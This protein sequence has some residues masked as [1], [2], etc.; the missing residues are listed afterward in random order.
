MPKSQQS[1]STTPNPQ[2]A[3]AMEQP[4]E[5]SSNRLPSYVFAR[6]TTAGP[7]DWS[8][9]SSESLFSIQMGNMSYTREQLNWMSKSGEH[10]YSHNLTP[11]ETPDNNQITAEITGQRSDSKE[12]SNG[13][14]EASE[15]E[16]MEKESQHKDNVPQD[17][18]HSTSVSR[19]SD[20]SLKSFAFPIL[21]GEADKNG[22]EAPCTKN[23]NQ[24]SLPSTPETIP[25]IPSETAS[26]QQTPP[27]S[28]KVEGESPKEASESPKETPKSPAPNAPKSGGP[29]KWLGCFSCCSS[30]S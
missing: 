18:P 28:P 1:D 20:A 7:T 24:P 14:I 13:V 26:K 25:E 6:T 5:E 16:T 9:C 22:T 27:E 15:T 4:A 29:R 30:G 8:M 17:L 23:K 10:N 11:P 21:T 19:N 3:A 2:T 12:G